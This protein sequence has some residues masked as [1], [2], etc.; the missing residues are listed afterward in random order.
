MA[1]TLKNTS[2]YLGK[3]GDTNWWEWTAY[4]EADTQKELDDI[5]YVEYRLHPSF[6]NPIVWVKKKDGGFQLKRK[7]WGVF[8]LRAKVLFKDKNKQSEHLEHY[9]EFE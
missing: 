9:L 2:K 6:K 8:L 5:D 7:G 1:I 4:I 3:E